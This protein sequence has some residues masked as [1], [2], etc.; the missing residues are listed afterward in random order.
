MV[1]V[2]EKYFRLIY[3]V[4]L[5][6]WYLSTYPHSA[7]GGFPANVWVRGG[8]NRFD[9][10]EEIARHFDRG[11]VSEGAEGQPDDILVCVIEVTGSR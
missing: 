1:P 2:I 11:N 6:V 9:F 5:Q 10:G 3:K 4:L 8:Q 7:D